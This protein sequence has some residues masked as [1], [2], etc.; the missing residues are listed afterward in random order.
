MSATNRVFYSAVYKARNKGIHK[1]VSHDRMLFR[2]P[3]T[4][5]SYRAAIWCTIMALIIYTIMGYISGIYAGNLQ[6]T[7]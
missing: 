4:K 5:G 1:G 6:G 2:I 7:L 3:S